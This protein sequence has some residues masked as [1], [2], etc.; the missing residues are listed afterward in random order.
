VTTT[1]NIPERQ[2]KDPLISEWDDRGCQWTDPNLR[3]ARQAPHRLTKR[4]PG[5]DAIPREAHKTLAVVGFAVEVRGTVLGAPRWIE[6]LVSGGVT[7]PWDGRSTND[8]GILHSRRHRSRGG[9]HLPLRG[10]VAVARPAR[11]K[12]RPLACYLAHDR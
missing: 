5:D 7:H 3:G 12:G 11:P 6:L 9:A 4:R 2:K 1:P 10:L 8:R